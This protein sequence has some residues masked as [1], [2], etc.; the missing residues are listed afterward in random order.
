[1][2]STGLTLKRGAAPQKPRPEESAALRF[3]KPKDQERPSETQERAEPTTAEK[4][5]ALEK[6]MATETMLSERAF[7]LSTFFNHGGQELISKFGS[8]R[9]LDAIGELDKGE[10]R[11]PNVFELI[12]QLEPNK[13]KRRLLYK[14]MEDMAAKALEKKEADEQKLSA[15]EDEE[16][17]RKFLRVYDDLNRS[18]TLGVQMT[19]QACRVMDSLFGR[20]FLTNEKALARFGL[21]PL[22]ASIRGSGLEALKSELGTSETEGDL[23]AAI[24]RIDG[25]RYE[26]RD[27]RMKEAGAIAEKL[28][29]EIRAIVSAAEGEL[30][31]KVNP[32]LVDLQ[33]TLEKHTGN[34]TGEQL[35]AKIAETVQKEIDQMREMTQRSIEQETA[36]LK[37]QLARASYVAGAR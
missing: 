26:M 1:M 7:A 18:K 8:T 4:I 25:Q 36:D 28:D 23:L 27:A 20:V 19:A 3:E 16:A 22:S 6:G 11:E 35:I 2:E 12:K 32:M 37:K 24:D 21:E 31:S 14:E 10:A 9:V 33:A 13:E 29:G 17:Y 5:D 30:A 15:G 34:D